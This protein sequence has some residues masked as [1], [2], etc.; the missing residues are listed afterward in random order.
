MSCLR[1]Q[2]ELPVQRDGKKDERLHYF[3]RYHS[4]AFCMPSNGN[5]YPAFTMDAFRRYACGW[6]GV[7][8]NCCILHSRSLDKVYKK[9]DLQYSMSFID[10]S[11]E[12]VVIVLG[13]K[14]IAS[15]GWI[16]TMLPTVF[17]STSETPDSSTLI[18]S[19][20]QV[21]LLPTNFSDCKVGI[22]N[23]VCGF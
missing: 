2:K 15:S 13:Y 20:F 1:I 16:F 6:I 19:K 10:Q 5:P 4:I 11:N 23:E 21:S 22:T 18:Q 8:H 12:V 7:V 3:S 14:K 9:F 17:S